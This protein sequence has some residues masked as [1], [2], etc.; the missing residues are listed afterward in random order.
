M[1]SAGS[2]TEKA[3]FVDGGDK[4]AFHPPNGT[5]WWMARAKRGIKAAETAGGDKPDGGNDTARYAV[6]A[7]RSE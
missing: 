7:E 6:L 2:S 4:R 1:K 5:Y 3:V